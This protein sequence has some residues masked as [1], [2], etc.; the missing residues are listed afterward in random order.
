MPPKIEIALYP[1]NRWIINP[2]TGERHQENNTTDTVNNLL[3]SSD[4]EQKVILERVDQHGNPLQEN[5]AWNILCAV[6][7]AAKVSGTVMRRGAKDPYPLET[8]LLQKVGEDGSYRAWWSWP[9]YKPFTQLN[10]PYSVTMT[11]ED[12]PPVVQTFTLTFIQ[13]KKG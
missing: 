6:K 1:T 11:L 8:L 12:K 5:L 4:A 9:N 10:D 2:K 13:E 7:G 3:C